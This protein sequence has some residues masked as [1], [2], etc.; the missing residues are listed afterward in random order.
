MYHTLLIP[1]DGSEMSRHAALRGL[2]LAG[3]LGARACALFVVDTRTFPGEL[4]ILPPSMA[5]YYASFTEELKKAGEAALE[6]LV[7]EAEKRSVKLT[8]EVRT[9]TPAAAI[10]EEV[11]R[12]GADLVVMGSHGRSGVGRLLLGSTT[13]A[14]LRGSKVPVLVVR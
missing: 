13:E 10:I 14:V 6:D 8:R 4:P 2:E 1:I 5:P 3:M 9:G 7:P 12:V 11:S